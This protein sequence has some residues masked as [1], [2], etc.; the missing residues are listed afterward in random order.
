VTIKLLR[1]SSPVVLL[2]INYIIMK[3][4]I[5]TSGLH[6]VSKIASETRHFSPNFGVVW[7]RIVRFFLTQ[8]TKTGKT[9]PY[10]HNSN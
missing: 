9:I 6:V 3:S 7:G 2:R 4:V 8:Y 10:Y 1:F 5:N